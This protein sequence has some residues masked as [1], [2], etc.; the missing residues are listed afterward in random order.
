MRRSLVLLVATGL[1][2]A[3]G[4]AAQPPII[5]PP[6]YMQ[7]GEEL[8]FGCDGY[9]QYGPGVAVSS[10]TATA[11]KIGGPDATCSPA[12]AIVSGACT[13]DGTTGKQRIVPGSRHGCD[14]QL[15]ITVTMAN[16][17]IVK[18]DRVIKVR[19]RSL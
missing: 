10:C 1:L 17:Q 16:T 6:Q 18:C 2:L 3:G 8:V 9:N 11:V 13:P 5:E 15:T 4:S 14:Y 7:P 19:T 12:S